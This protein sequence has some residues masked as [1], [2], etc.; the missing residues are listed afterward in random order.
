MVSRRFG[1]RPDGR[2]QVV[3]EAGDVLQGFDAKTGERLWSSEVIGEGKVPSVVLGGGL[4]FTSGGWGG[5]ETIKAFKLGGSGEMKET[6]L[7]WEQRKGMPKIPSMIFL[8]PH[9]FA[10][11]DGGIATCLKADTGEILW[12]ERVGGN[13]SAS[14]RR[15]S[16]P[17]L[18][19][20]RQWRDNRHRGGVTVQSPREKPSRRKAASLACVFGRPDIHPHRETPLV[21][22]LKMSVSALKHP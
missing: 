22:W 19:L 16:G 14:P 1:W 7:V 10:I 8:A 2:A 15:G 12:Q 13:F 11:T 3:S 6:H 5:K 18:F 17:H 9:L 20:W 4:A 21:H